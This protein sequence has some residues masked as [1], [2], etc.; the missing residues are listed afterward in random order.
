MDHNSINIGEILMIYKSSKSYKVK[1]DV[2]L[3]LR[4]LGLEDVEFHDAADEQIQNMRVQCELKQATVNSTD[5]ELNQ[6]CTGC[7]VI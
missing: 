2:R 7:S 6:N 1:I 3:P 5:D 4:I